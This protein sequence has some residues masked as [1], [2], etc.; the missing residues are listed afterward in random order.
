M[1]T[2]KSPAE[3]ARK[4][5]NLATVTQRRQREA[6][7]RG[8]LVT[9]E[10]IIAEAESAGVSRSSTIAGGKWG[11]GFDVKGFNNPSALVKVRGPFHLVDSPTKPHTIPKS[12]RNRKSKRLAFPDG[13]VR[14]SVQHPGTSGKRTFPKA[15]IKASRAVPRVMA[16]SI[17]SGWRAALK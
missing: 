4:I 17:V 6:V 9:K 8:A 16:Q 11:V 10:L 2:S 12:R 3:F 7:T 5:T 15:T 14:V 13:G 1:G